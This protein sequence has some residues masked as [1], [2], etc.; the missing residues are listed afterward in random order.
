MTKN[1]KAKFIIWLLLI[2]SLAVIGLQ[3]FW[4]NNAFRMNQQEESRLI[5][6]AVEDATAGVRLKVLFN[7]ENDKSSSAKFRLLKLL[8]DIINETEKEEQEKE[9]ASKEVSVIRLNQENAIKDDSIIRSLKTNIT[10]DVIKKKDSE[11]SS[12][13]D[14]ADSKG[15]GKKIGEFLDSVSLNIKIDNKKVNIFDDKQLKFLL[16]S[17]IN[18]N[19]EKFLLHNKFETII[20]SS[21]DRVKDLDSSNNEIIIHSRIDKDTV[22]YIKV[23]PHLYNNL[24]NMKWLFLMSL[25]IVGFLFYAA[26]SI[27]QSFNR[28]KQLSEIKNDFISNMTHEFK[29]P[30]ATVTLAIEMIQNFGIKNDPGKLDEYLGICS[31]ELLRVTNMIETVLRLAQDKPYILEKELVNLPD[32]L[33]KFERQQQ[34]RLEGNSVKINLSVES[35]EFPLIKLDAVHFENILYNLLDNSVKYSKGSPEININLV[36]R[37]DFFELTFKDNGIGIAREFQDKIFDNFFRVPSGNIHNIKGFGLG[38]SYV[39]KI[40]ELHGGKI[41]VS[42]RPLNGTTF[43]MIIP[44]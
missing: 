14:P 1:K 13:V 44:I 22:A 42:S 12:K 17:A 23:S 15:A 41:M 8:T 6:L 19:F 35:T 20:Q 5:H 24:S 40:V 2:S 18:Q 39:K 10:N 33:I 31:G 11:S 30:I 29:T 27:I 26:L 28:E 25:L 9:G 4:L 32:V 3:L 21:A 7:Y 43:V 38:L 37:N 34:T 36:R 16:D